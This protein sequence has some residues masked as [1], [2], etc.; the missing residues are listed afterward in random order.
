MMTMTDRY[1]PKRYG[2]RCYNLQLL[3]II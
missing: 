2:R 3:A 1:A